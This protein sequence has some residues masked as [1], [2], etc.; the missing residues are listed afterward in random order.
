M[1]LLLFITKDYAFLRL[2]KFKIKII[3]DF[4]KLYFLNNKFTNM[5]SKSHNILVLATLLLGIICQV[6]A[7]VSA[8]PPMPGP[9]PGPMPEPGPM[10]IPERNCCG[11]N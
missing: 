5:S 3:F 8:L 10:P 7:K 11:D 6:Q 4:Y 1:E 9:M 2:L